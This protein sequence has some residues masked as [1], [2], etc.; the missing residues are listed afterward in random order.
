MKLKTFIT[1]CSL[2]KDTD[3]VR[4]SAASDR[5]QPVALLG[6]MLMSTAVTVTSAA[7]PAPPFPGVQ[8]PE[9]DG[10]EL[11]TREWIPGDRRSHG[12]D[13]LGP[14]FNDSS[15]VACHNQGGTGGSGSASKNVD[16]VTAFHA[17]ANRHDQQNSLPQVTLPGILFQSVFGNLDHAGVRQRQIRNAETAAAA[18]ADDSEKKDDNGKTADAAEEAEAQ[19]KEQAE[20]RKKMA[21]A[22]RKF[23][24]RMHPGF[25][26]SNSV[27]LHRDATFQGYRQWRSRA[28]GMQFS[29]PLP[30]EQQTAIF[31][32]EAAAVIKATTAEATTAGAQR[33]QVQIAQLRQEMQLNGSGHNQSQ[34]QGAFV[35]TKSQRNATALFGAGFID[36]IPD[37]VLETLATAQ[38]KNP[39][40][41][42]RVARLKDGRAGRFG[43]KAQKSRLSDFVLTACAVEVGL[44]VPGH[45]QAG[46]PLN[47]AYTPPG[48]DLN[49]AE[50]NALIQYIAGL[51]APPQR[52]FAD[53]VERQYIQGGHALFTRVGCADCHVEKVGTV[54]GI[55][56]DLL[57]HNMGP[58]LGDTGSYDV[59]IPDSTP[60]GQ[61]LP[62]ASRTGQSADQAGQKIVGAT[63][64]EWRT[65]PLWGIRDSGPYLHDG[66]AQTLAQAI[67]LHGGESTQSTQKFF[68]LSDA[69]QFQVLSFMKSLVAPN[70]QTIAT[71]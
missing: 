3:F 51:P 63:H 60:A 44:N 4:T 14:V 55:F 46:H 66:R 26:H 31:E 42:G 59:F 56:S 28:G 67:A 57:L 18:A 35:I 16:I 6:A 52:D 69:E 2:E 50:C 65:P 23:L 62:L 37:T 71:R 40:I 25:A 11:F 12:G 30:Q 15:C 34:R 48:L 5:I 70:Q 22:E 49:Q 1:M 36:S 27:V 13:G 54:A 33:G 24:A 61:T 64:Q 38:Q 41:S 19:K 8:A 58:E 7:E 32:V 29:F 9:T 21:A 20:L 10:A 53:D 47:P 17:P 39:L 45:P 43:W 68:A